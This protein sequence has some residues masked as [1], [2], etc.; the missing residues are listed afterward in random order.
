VSAAP[1]EP[2]SGPYKGLAA[3]DESELDALL[4]FGRTRDTEIIAANLLASRLTVLYGPSGVGKSSVLRAGVARHLRSVAPH[5]HVAVHDSWSG[6]AGRNVLYGLDGANDVYLLLDQFEEVFA[7]RGASGLAA[8]VARVVTAPDL[9]VN[10]LLSLRDDALSELDVFTGRVQNVFGN[11]LVLERLD[12]ASARQAVTGPLERYNE[13]VPERQVAVGDDLVEAVLDQVEVGRVDVGGTARGAVDE[14]SAGGIEAPYLQLVMDRLWVAE[15]ELGSSTLRRETLDALGGAEAIVQAHLEE[16]LGE[17]TVEQQD[18]AASVFNH[19]VTPSGTKVAHEAGDLAEYARVREDALEP[20]VE[21]LSRSRIL[22]PADGRVE[23]FH[24]VLSEA[25]SGW[26]TRHERE[27]ALA[28]QRAEAERRHRRLLAL[29]A[30]SLVVLGVMAAV[31]IYAI[32]QRSEAQEQADVARSEELSATANRLAAEAGILLPPAQAELDP[33]LALLLAREAVRLEPTARAVNILRR[34]LL[35]SHLRAVLP[36][37]GVTTASFSLDGER[38]LVGTQD[39]TV[40]IHSS[41]DLTRLTILDVGNPVT[42]AA[43]SP[44]GERVLTTEDNEP[45]KLW[46]LAGGTVE[47][48]FGAAVR[49]A[50]LNSGGTLALTVE[51]DAVRIW[52]VSDGSVV[53]TLA[54]PGG[55]RQA[56]FSPDGTSV[57]SFGAGRAQVFDALSGRLVADAEHGSEVTSAS[58]SPDGRLLVTTGR[59]G[60][61]R[62]WSIADGGR[63]LRVLRGHSGQITAGVVSPDGTLLTT[64]GTEGR[65][66]VWEVPAG[67]FVTTLTGHPNRV[68]GAAF[69]RDSQSVVT[70]DAGGLARVGS[71]RS[72]VPSALLAGHPDAVTGASFDASGDVVLTTSADGRARLWRAGVDTALRPLTTV[73]DPVNEAAYGANGDVVAAST[74]EGLEILETSRGGVLSEITSVSAHAVALSRDGSSVAAASGDQV[75]IWDAEGGPPRSIDETAT[76]LAFGPDGDLALGMESGSIGIWA[77]D[78]SRASLLEGASSGRV[79]SVGFDAAGDRLAAGFEDGTLAVWRLDTEARLYHVAV[80][81]AATRVASVAFSPDGRQIVTA[82]G[83]LTARV[84]NAATGRPFY[85]LR[86]HSN[87]VRAAAYSPNGDWLLTTASGAAGI[88][89]AATRQRLLLLQGEGTLLTSS[90]DSSSVR[91]TTVARSGMLSAYSCEVCVSVHELLELAESRLEAT[92]RELTAAERRHYLG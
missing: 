1:P 61:A 83:E 39:G 74:A 20:V 66:Q 88:W 70:W 2:L 48:S 28:V 31:T 62:L 11:Y 68:G 44:D 43:F 76:A 7:Y 23:I 35:V 42:G 9:R 67:R 71:P 86:A 30:A 22:R 73:P 21:S 38:L 56:A 69:S 59:D 6:G 40:A 82:G 80:N 91:V 72:P 16:A 18:M 50:S 89:D 29:L 10:V 81:R 5:A 75:S 90:F 3:F 54:Q 15:R 57:V 51:P 46:G 52:R 13:L 33:E 14:T 49:F 87:I 63:P 77:Q 41:D 78:G 8:E 24:D 60:V 45:A 19:L 85:A 26:R 32:T 27:R 58:I 4:F 17:L 64:T 55:A 92:G 34:A 84:W 12:R 79:T 37:E 65:A 53:S 47:R 25:V 36:E